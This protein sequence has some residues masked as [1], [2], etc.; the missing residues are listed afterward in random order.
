MNSVASALVF[1]SILFP[2]KQWY[3]PDQAL[4]I[5]MRDAP[6]DTSLVLIDAQGKQL[7]AD[8]PMEFAADHSIDI[9]RTWRALR[10]PGTYY[11]LAVPQGKHR[12]Q[13]IGTPLV[14]DVRDDTRRD[15]LPGP[16]VVKIDPL[17]YATMST[18]KGDM[19][20][21]FY[22]DSAP[23]TVNS[24][25]SLA[26]G[27]FFDGMKF[28]R[29][30]PG[31]VL[32]TGDPRGDGTGGPGYH[33]EAEFNSRKHEEGALSMARQGDPIEKQGQM[34]RPEYANS[35][36]SQFFI[37]L[38][39]KNTMQLDGRY[40]VFG[41]IVSG[42]DTARTIAKTPTDPKTDAPTQPQIIRSVTVVPVTADKNPYADLLLLQP[43]TMPV[44]AE[45]P[46]PPTTMP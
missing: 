12:S 19:N 46:V 32:Q 38:D 8:G 10:N 5:T 9:S 25:L 39:Y 21:I 17:C 42:M 13:F 41:K 36:G 43:L 33:I 28:H 35:A 34:P 1:F 37:C 16:M 44:P 20:L 3:A 18:E 2:S 22:Y 24:F 29:L 11:L 45:M 40:T 15:A 26:R 23:H 30:I 27:G 7:E 14:V 31:F 6:A 4:M